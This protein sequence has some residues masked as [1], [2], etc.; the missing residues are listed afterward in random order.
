MSEIQP[1]NPIIS[2]STMY[3]TSTQQQISNSEDHKEEEFEQEEVMESTD[4][5]RIE[6]ARI[7]E[8]LVHK[9]ISDQEKS[10]Y[11]VNQKVYSELERLK[12]AYPSIDESLIIR[13]VEEFENKEQLEMTEGG[14]EKKDPSKF[15][16]LKGHYPQI[17]ESLIQKEIQDLEIKDAF[18]KKEKD[19][20]TKSDATALK[21]SNKKGNKSD[22]KEELALPN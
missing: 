4:Y 9:E 5:P 20:V 18:E 6:E 22:K 13:E 14:P 2:N 19:K 17:D 21:S 12:P 3:P 15:E 16:E 7:D 10:S 1:Y 8:S 11:G